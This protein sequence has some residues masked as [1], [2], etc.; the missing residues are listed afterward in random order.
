T[1]VYMSISLTCIAWQILT[2]CGL[3]WAS[4]KWLHVAVLFNVSLPFFVVMTSL[5]SPLFSVNCEVVR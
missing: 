1:L 4:R 3:L 5:L 2:A